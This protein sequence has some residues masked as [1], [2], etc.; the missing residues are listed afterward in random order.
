M[1]VC[2][3]I[4]LLFKFDWKISERLFDVAFM[5]NLAFHNSTEYIF[6]FSLIVLCFIVVLL[7][8]FI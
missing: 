8:N 1:T 3:L 2:F 6:A 5:S 7:F 4:V